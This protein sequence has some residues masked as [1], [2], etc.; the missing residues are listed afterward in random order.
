ML[1]CCCHS[2]CFCF[3]DWEMLH[4]VLDFWFLL[5]NPMIRHP[6]ACKA[7]LQE[8]RPSCLFRGRLCCPGHRSFTWPPSPLTSPTLGT[9]HFPAP[10]LPP[11]L[12]A[13]PWY[14]QECSWGTR[15]RVRSCSPPPPLP[16]PGSL[17][18]RGYRLPFF[19]AP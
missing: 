11:P 17:F 10:S 12:Y 15:K 8:L 4:T 16:S 18:L 6:H 19:F 9:L 3:S 2:C 7:R 14:L 13:S 5:K 1:V